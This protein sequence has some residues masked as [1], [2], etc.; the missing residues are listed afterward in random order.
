MMAVNY[1]CIRG[2]LHHNFVAANG[3]KIHAIDRGE[4]QRTT[5]SAPSFLGDRHGLLMMTM[6]DDYLNQDHA[7]LLLPTTQLA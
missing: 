2:H 4:Q 6:N 7:S 5:A 3:G 1:G